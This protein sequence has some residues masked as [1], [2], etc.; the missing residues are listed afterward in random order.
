[1]Q[2]LRSFEAKE[3]SKNFSFD[4]SMYSGKAGTGPDHEGICLTFPVR[5]GRFPFEPVGTC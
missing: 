1:M 3:Q 4:S 5:E 2:R